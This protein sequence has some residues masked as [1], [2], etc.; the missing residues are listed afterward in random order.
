MASRFGRATMGTTSF[1]RFG[2]RWIAS[3]F[4]QEADQGL[5]LPSEIVAEGHIPPQVHVAYR[6]AKKVPLPVPEVRAGWNLWPMLKAWRDK[7]FRKRLKP[8]FAS[9]R[10]FNIATIAALTTHIR[11]SDARLLDVEAKLSA[12][13]KD[14]DRLNA[15]LR[16][17]ASSQNSSN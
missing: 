11:N 16:M 15:L 14:V 8:L 6:L 3:A 1:P 17:Q 2:S 4:K 12:L 5:R 9:Q 13:A 10:E 7:R